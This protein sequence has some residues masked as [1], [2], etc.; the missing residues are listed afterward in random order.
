M[1]EKGHNLEGN[2]IKFSSIGQLVMGVIM[3]VFVLVYF[4]GIP[5][6]DEIALVVSIMVTFVVGSE[7]LSMLGWLIAGIRLGLLKEGFAI[8]RPTQ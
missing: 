3:L 2:L 1:Q 7:L 6:P 8:Q 5:N 4:S